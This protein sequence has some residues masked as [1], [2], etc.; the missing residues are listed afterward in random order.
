MKCVIVCSHRNDKDSL[1]D[2]LQSTV[3]THSSPSP[4]A[5]GKSKWKVKHNI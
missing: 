2:E 5:K 3:A 4:M 1:N